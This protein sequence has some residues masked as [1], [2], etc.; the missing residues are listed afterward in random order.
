MSTISIDAARP[1]ALIQIYDIP[2]LHSLGLIWFSKEQPALSVKKRKENKYLNLRNYSNF[3]SI[4][5]QV[6]P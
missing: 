5:G 1:D 2:G 6:G 3:V 4:S